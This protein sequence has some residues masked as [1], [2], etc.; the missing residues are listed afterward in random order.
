MASLP[1]SLGSRRILLFVCLFAGAILTFQ[2]IRIRVA[3][4]RV[5]S[6]QIPQMERGAAL[7]PENAA[8]WDR[9][10]RARETDFANLD[11]AGA[12]ADFQKAVARVPLSASHW[13]D[14]GDATLYFFC[15]KPTWQRRLPFLPAVPCH[16][17]AL[18]VA[19][20]SSL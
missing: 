14:L 13:M 3:D 7:E 1:E 5:H 17:G 11:P 19:N 2:A 12:V 6:T 4:Y 15:F 20:T 16:A 18:T 9:L 8:A 10:G